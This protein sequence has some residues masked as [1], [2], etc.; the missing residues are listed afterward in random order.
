M[1]RSTLQARL[2]PRRVLIIPSRQPSTTTKSSTGAEAISSATTSTAV[3]PNKLHSH[4]NNNTDESLSSSSPSH[5]PTPLHVSTPLHPSLTTV[6]TTPIYHPSPLVE[7]AVHQASE[8]AS[9]PQE[10]A[11]VSKLADD[12]S[13]VAFVMKFTDWVMRAE[14]PVV[15]A[16]FLSR[17]VSSHQIPAFMSSIDR[18]LVS[19]GSTFAPYLP[20]IVVESAR[21]RM[22]SIVSTFV[23][24]VDRIDFTKQE[25][26]KNVNLLGEAVLGEKEALRRR[27][28]AEELL[29][30]DG[31]DYVSV[32]VSGVTSQLSKWDFDGSLNRVVDS[33][34]PLF[35]KA[36]ASNPRVLINLDMEE[37]HD[38]EI[39][40]EA[41]TKILS[42]P[43]FQHLDAGIVLQAYLPDALP[44][45]QHLVHWANNERPGN[46]QIKIRLVKG[47]N[48]AMEKVD[49]DIHGWEQTPYTSKSD[50]DANYLRCLDW[51]FTPDNLQRVRIGVASHNL[52]TLA[53]AKFLA[54]ERQVQGQVGF[55]NLTGMTPSHTPV[56]AKQGHGM[57]LYT[58]VCRLRDFDVA[59]SY[60]FRR[61]EETSSPGNFLRSLP[62]LSATSDSFRMEET[63]FRTAFAKQHIVPVGPRRMQERPAPACQMTLKGLSNQP[64]VFINEPDSD[65]VL[66]NVREWAIDAVRPEKYTPASEESWVTSVSHMEEVLQRARDA[67]DAW[68]ASTTPSERRAVL[69][70]V[71]DVMARR[72]GDFLNVMVNEGSK[73]I[74]ES[75]VE[76]SEG[77]DFANYYGLMAEELPSNF[78]KLGVVTV[79]APWNFP[80][81]IG[82]GGALA[83]IAAGNAAILKP[84]PNTPRCLELVAECAWEAGVPKDLL[85]FVQCPENEVGQHLITESDAVILTGASET[86]KMFQSWKHDLR[87]FAEVSF[88]STPLTRPPF[89]PSFTSDNRHKTHP[90]HPIFEGLLL[91]D[92]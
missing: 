38:L 58:P 30:R 62:S 67:S 14:S 64:G 56:L 17:L 35:Q 41:F 89:F 44:A 39:T 92:D 1:I 69:T 10:D 45:L 21:I 90:Y 79:A 51:A 83:A 81:A 59:I 46:A 37:Y 19:M 9:I 66:A 72:R 27:E 32:K 57:L 12:S 7:Q 87:L 54:K 16:S 4:N 70:R 33:L 2:L 49:A 5:H 80:S 74:S 55:E 34:R 75:D 43:Q 61:F 60:L 53:Y 71:A 76:I 13:A 25:M 28:E 48:L 68:S 52:F 40:V 18:L 82:A 15:A 3:N 31:V 73:T 22:R 29:G 88:F 36:A 23:G 84:S 91:T 50:T 85:Q 63:R 8:W 6:T 20:T 26:A 11:L 86:A 65:P 78:E 42:E 24:T 77:I 47:A